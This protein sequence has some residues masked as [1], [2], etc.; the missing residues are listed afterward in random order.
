MQSRLA[1]SVFKRHGRTCPFNHL[2]A[3]CLEERLNTRPFE[4]PVDRLRPDR[5]KRL[6]VLVVHGRNDIGNLEFCNHFAPC[7]SQHRRGALLELRHAHTWIGNYLRS[8]IGKNKADN[9]PASPSSRGEF[10]K[11]IHNLYTER[12][13]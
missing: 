2:A 5:L 4:I 10:R 6:S 12:T 3:K 9:L 11:R 8:P 1:P 7:L 13:P